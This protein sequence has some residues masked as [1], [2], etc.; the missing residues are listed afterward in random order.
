DGLEAHEDA[1][2]SSTPEQ[3]EQLAVARVL[4]AQEAFVAAVVEALGDDAPEQLQREVSPDR[5]QVVDEPDVLREAPP[6]EQLAYHGVDR[7][8]AV[9]PVEIRRD[10]ELARVRA[11]AGGLDRH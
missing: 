5:E 9:A 3:G 11:A 7:L 2:E 6:L 1:V 8:L 4:H 10:A